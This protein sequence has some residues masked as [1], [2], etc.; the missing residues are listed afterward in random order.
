MRTKKMHKTP[1][2][3]VLSGMAARRAAAWSLLA[4]ACLFR[5]GVASGA[6]EPEVLDVRLSHDTMK[7]RVGAPA[8]VLPGEGYPSAAVRSN[9]GSEG[10]LR[11]WI[12][13]EEDGRPVET[14]A[15]RTLR[16]G[17]TATITFDRKPEEGRY[18]L[19]LRF[20]VG[21]RPVFQDA[22]YFSVFDPAA[23]PAGHSLIAHPGRDGKMVYIPD[24]RGNRIPDFSLVGYM[25]GAEEIPDVPVKAVVEPG[26][27]KDDQRIQA[28]INR[29]AA[30]DPDENGFRGAV[31]LKKGVYRVG[32]VNIRTGG[33]VLRGEGSGGSR[34]TTL[35]DPG[36]PLDKGNFMQKLAKMD[37]TFLIT[38][39]EP[40]HVGGSGIKEGEKVTEVLDNYVPVGATTF[41]VRD[42]GDLKAGDTVFVKR[43]AN[44]AWIHAIGMDRIPGAKRQWT[45]HTMNF[46]RKITAVDGERVTIDA[47]IL[48]AIESRWGGGSVTRVSD[49]GRISQ[50]GVENMRMIQYVTL[51]KESGL[52]R[53]R[54]LAVQFS[55]VKDSWIR[56][57]VTEHYYDKGT[58]WLKEAT[59]NITITGCSNLN[60]DDVYFSGYVPRYAI[61]IGGGGHS[62]FNL[63][64]NGYV[65]NYRHAYYVDYRVTGPNVFHN[66]VGEKD[67]TNSEPHHLWSSGGLYDTMD[68]SMAFMNRLTY[69]S[70]HGWAGAN[71]VAWNTRGRLIC[72]R[73]PTAQN[74]AVGH[75]GFR[76]QGPFHDWRPK[77]DAESYDGGGYGYWELHQSPVRIDV[78]ASGFAYGRAP[79][80]TLDDHPYTY[81]MVRRLSGWIQYDLQRPQTLSA[82]RMSFPT[83][84]PYR[85]AKR[86]NDPP[87][88][89]DRAYFFDVEVSDDGANWKRVLKGGKGL[90]KGHD[91]FQT[92]E[93]PEVRARYVRIN[94]NG[95]SVGAT[96]ERNS[97][98]FHV[99]RVRFIPEPRFDPAE[100]V[101]EVTPASLYRRQVNER[102]GR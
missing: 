40:F 22:Y 67:I 24:Y 25:S 20:M 94:A 81:W 5:P 31:L 6:G 21:D 11:G 88:E 101:P 23:L 56:D 100:P 92:F 34:Q 63:V 3:T 74:W 29:V 15:P 18:R 51:D 32:R 57:V 61:K 71:Y 55:G 10:T 12:V 79:E 27:G 1:L 58:F 68:G 2:L 54:G 45:P 89:T 84:T 76:V 33:V 41:S 77:E 65:K 43:H 75:R 17:Q 102:Y 53:Y 28:A 82:L 87:P 83:Q 85:S 60:A 50:V 44:D 30:M 62:C 38:D 37:G 26:E 14:V 39:H 98:W 13:R 69:G 52:G 86:R 36:K 91:A 73:P 49:A 48:T 96:G 93:F 90:A 97:N 4:L 66:S 72:E 9:H 80:S 47:P 99:N 16:Q 59:R 19:L 35:H 42:P 70:G 78:Q 7:T 95:S 8:I 64:E 46:E